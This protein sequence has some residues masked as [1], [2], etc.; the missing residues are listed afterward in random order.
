MLHSDSFATKL[1]EGNPAG[2]CVLERRLPLEL[3]QKIAEENNL[4]ETA[5]IVKNE[6]NYELRWFTPKAEIDLCG[7]ATLAAAYVISN[8]IDINVQKIDFLTQ[9]GNLEVTRNGNLYE[10]IF[11]EIMPTEIELSPQQTNLIGCIPSAV[12]SLRDLVLLLNSE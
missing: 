9:N 11:P 7:H 5:F 3:M 1:F 4:P 8:F 2:V 6:G 10:M 12:Y